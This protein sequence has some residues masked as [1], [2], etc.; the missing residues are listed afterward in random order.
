MPSVSVFYF[1]HGQVRIKIKPRRDRC[2]QGLCRHRLSA[3]HALPVHIALRR[4]EAEAVFRGHDDKHAASV[5]VAARHDIAMRAR[6]LRT[7]DQGIDPDR[8][9]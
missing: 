9:F 4:I 5:T 7:A 2:G 1:D 8:C 3:P 6:D